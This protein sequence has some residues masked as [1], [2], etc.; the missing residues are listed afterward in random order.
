LFQDGKVL[1]TGGNSTGAAIN[2]AELYDPDSGAFTAVGDMAFH[3]TQHTA[4]L[5]LNGKVS[6]A[7]YSSTST[8]ELFDPGTQI[9][10]IAGQMTVRRGDCT[11]TLLQDG[12]VLIAGSGFK[13]SVGDANESAELYDPTT[14]TFTVTGSM[15]VPREFG[16]TATL[17]SDGKA[18]TVGGCQGDGCYAREAELYNPETGTFFTVGNITTARWDHTASLLPDGRVLLAGSNTLGSTRQLASAELGTRLLSSV[19]LPL[20]SR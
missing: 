5:L 6:I 10:S 9:F 19:W 2:S 15:A 20:I 8:T 4:T 1:I 14:G 3:R 18:L 7:G 11:A 17:L 13:I 16:H 12:K